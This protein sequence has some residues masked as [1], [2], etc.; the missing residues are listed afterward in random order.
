MH[1]FA[2]SALWNLQQ[3][4]GAQDFDVATDLS[5]P[6][7]KP[8]FFLLGPHPLLLP[9]SPVSS[10]FSSHADQRLIFRHSLCPFCYI[11]SVATS[12]EFF[13][14]ISS[15][16]SFPPWI[17]PLGPHVRTPDDTVWTPGRIG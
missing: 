4:E 1:L 7:S 5:M 10:F 12:P 13:C 6:Q 11:H 9:T 15:H 3:Y 17:S 2:I 16:S 14:L 8:T